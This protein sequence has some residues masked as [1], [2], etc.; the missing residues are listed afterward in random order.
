[1]TILW[2]TNAMPTSLMLQAKKSEL[3][4]F[5]L[6]TLERKKF[7]KDSISKLHFTTTDAFAKNFN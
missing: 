4:L 3:N 6:I 2:I 7:T 1:M 5:T